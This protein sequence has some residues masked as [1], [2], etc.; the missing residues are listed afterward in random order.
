[1]IIPENRKLLAT[2]VTAAVLVAIVIGLYLAGSPAEARLLRLDDRRVDDLRSISSAL[3]EY[4]RGRGHLPPTLDS[5]PLAIGDAP[6]LRDPV[7]LQ[8]YTY[9][10]TG[11]S[12]Y[13]LCAE[14][15]RRS[16]SE[17][18]GRYEAAWRH[19]PGHFCFPLMAS[20]RP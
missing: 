7:T 10:V 17:R 3:A 19:L 18:D 1:M 13:S 6:K 14:F 20:A 2:V 4:R 9:E 11:D 16:P 5:L 15:A 12:S 8:P